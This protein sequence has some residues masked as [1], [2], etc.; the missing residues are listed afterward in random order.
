MRTSTGSVTEEAPRP[1]A[2][3][4]RNEGFGAL[5]QK[6]DVRRAVAHDPTL[7][8]AVAAEIAPNSTF[9]RSCAGRRSRRFDR[10]LIARHERPGLRHC[11]IATRCAVGSELTGIGASDTEF[12]DN[13]TD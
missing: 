12:S 2:P 9:H 3:A 10:R 11:A 6:T 5:D 4:F 8:R 13:L 7:V 1:G